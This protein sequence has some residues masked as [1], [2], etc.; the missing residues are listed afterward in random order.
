MLKSRAT[1][2]PGL[3]T[4]FWLIEK[5]EA[6]GRAEVLTISL[7]D[8]RDALPVFS[9]EEEARLF[10]RLRG[11]SRGW[12]IRETTTRELVSLLFGQ[13]AAAGWI[14]L[15]PVPEIG[16]EALVG[17]VSLKREDF[18]SFLGLATSV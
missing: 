4:A 12:R 13:R 16:G 14:A 11:P 7:E 17:I 18:V 5:H 2:A 8:G 10:L 1:R 15:D 6:G 9:F 3:T